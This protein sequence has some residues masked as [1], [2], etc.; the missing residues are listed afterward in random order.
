MFL[1]AQGMDSL[2]R[3]FV[4]QESDGED[5]KTPCARVDSG[6]MLHFATSFWF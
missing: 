4:I 6:V 3:V 5:L 1:I 2:Y